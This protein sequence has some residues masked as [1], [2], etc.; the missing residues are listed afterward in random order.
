MSKST[1][2]I[3]EETDIYDVV[4]RFSQGES[5]KLIADELGKS[6]QRVVVLLQKAFTHGLVNMPLLAP[7]KLADQLQALSPNVQL[8]VINASNQFF[9]LAALQ[10]LRWIR[11]ICATDISNEPWTEHDEINDRLAYIAV[12]GGSTMRNVAKSLG[13]VVSSP[14]NAE[15][16]DW[17]AGQN[18]RLCF[19]NATAGG[20]PREP[21]FESSYVACHFAQSCG[22]HAAVYSLS[23][24]PSNEEA[25]L[26]ECGVKNTTLL[27]SG[28]GEP[29]RAYC[30]RAM[31]DRRILLPEMRD[32]LVGEFV[33]HP[34]DRDGESLLYTRNDAEGGVEVKEETLASGGQST[35]DAML[36]TLLRFDSLKGRPAQ[37][38]HWKNGARGRYVAAIAN[39]NNE[40]ADAKAIAVNVLLNHGFLTHLCVSL[41]LAERIVSHSRRPD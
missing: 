3:H 8:S 15:L 2:L 21:D 32:K 13:K 17:L 1:Q 7:S 29:K 18:G 40:N 33:F 22:Q 16:T 30:I 14:G 5:I 20:L 11:E 31:T 34:F 37:N 19:L 28:I 10:T 39:C 9:S 35:G 23:G 12:G 38:A 41:E 6:R 24:N 25:E 27:I 36:A 26:V 4:F